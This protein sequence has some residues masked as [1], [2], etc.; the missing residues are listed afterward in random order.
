MATHV[1]VSPR[2]SSPEGEGFQPSPMGTLKI[3]RETSITD[4]EELMESLD[5]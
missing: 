3:G 2:F 5:E 1:A 4:E